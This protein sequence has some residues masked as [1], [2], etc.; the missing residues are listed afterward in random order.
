MNRAQSC[1]LPAPIRGT[2]FHLQ[3]RYNL[4]KTVRKRPIT[5]AGLVLG[6]YHFDRT[7]MK[8]EVRFSV[9][10]KDLEIRRAAVPRRLTDVRQQHQARLSRIALP[11]ACLAPPI[12]EL[13]VEEALNEGLANAPPAEHEIIGIDKEARGNGRRRAATGGGGRPSALLACRQHARPDTRARKCTHFSFPSLSPPFLLTFSRSPVTV[14]CSPFAVR[15][16]SPV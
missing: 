8:H 14:R 5:A 1:S 2:S 16:V 10:G 11:P 15:P 9:R 7:D 6:D 12:Q 3:N 13:E 4:T